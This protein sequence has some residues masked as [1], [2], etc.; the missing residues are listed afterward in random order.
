MMEI[1]TPRLTTKYFLD[2][3]DITGDE[4]RTCL[5]KT[6]DIWQVFQ[7][8]AEISSRIM[9]C[10]AVQVQ[11]GDGLPHVICYS[12]RELLDV[13][14]NFKCQVE[15]SDAKFRE[16]L[17]MQQSMLQSDAVPQ[18]VTKVITET[19][20][21]EISNRQMEGISHESESIEVYQT[22]EY[23]H[24]ENEDVDDDDGEEVP[25]V[26]GGATG[27]STNDKKMD[28]DISPYVDANEI[29]RHEE[30]FEK[31]GRNDLKAEAI[32]REG[33]DCQNHQGDKALDERSGK[34]KPFYLMLEDKSVCESHCG[35]E[36]IDVKEEV[37]VNCHQEKEFCNKTCDE[38]SGMSIQVTENKTNYRYVCYMCEKQFVSVEKLKSHVADSHNSL[39]NPEKNDEEVDP[40]ETI[41]RDETEICEDDV[42]G[43]VRKKKSKFSCKYCPKK[44][45]Y[46]KSFST[47]AKRHPEYKKMEKNGEGEEKCDERRFQNDSDDDEMPLE[48]LQ[49]TQCGKLFATKRNLKRHISTH[50]GLKFNCPT[51]QKE[52]S[53]ADKLK[54]HEQSKH[55]N[56]FFSMSDE[57]NDSDSENDSENKRDYNSEGRKK[58][59]NQKPHQCPICPRTF[60][61][62]QTLTNHVER[63][64]R[65]KQPQKR[66]LCEVCS[67]CFAQS[68]S[69]VAH[70]R[71]HTGVKPYVCNVCSRAF[72]KSTYLQLHLRTHSGEKPYICQYCS[73]AFARANTLARHITMHTGEAK[74]HC[75]IC[76][77]SFRRLTS[78]NEHTYTHT[79][80]RP[81]ACKICTKRYNNA[82]SLYAHTKKCK[83]QQ[84][85][86][87]STIN[88]PVSLEASN[89]DDPSVSMNCPPSSIL[90]YTD[91]KCDSEAPADAEQPIPE[92]ILPNVQPEKSL[93]P[94]IIQS[95]STHDPNYY[96][97]NTKT[98]K[99]FYYTTYPS[100]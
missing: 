55:R 51:C 28:L 3:D 83:A 6:T 34:E 36:E 69:L 91:K 42:S 54:E 99:N 94:N 41:T 78:L 35:D 100:L 14:Y 87:N 37:L 62:S 2:N 32:N 39:E 15:Q 73:R 64:K 25:V 61:H 13:S 86:S 8:D 60:A 11:E 4:C 40:G 17:K 89:P 47:H 16:A 95:A 5:K 85:S 65:I 21:D 71:T 93:S 19:I 58:D 81:Y 44:F 7:S 10:A 12:C 20:T 66:F 24:E 79:G 1:F 63:H 67:K 18:T 53:R 48:G 50:S 23:L 74:Y 29:F 98:F 43:T 49:C 80:Q 27:G 84:L 52:F 82:G 88:Y 22:E 9:A 38:L 77:K 76:M 97:V 90:I 30:T 75:Q 33:V 68:G 59:K 45:T 26:F 70:M 31:S 92:F 56:E 72:T 96:S 57:N 46:E